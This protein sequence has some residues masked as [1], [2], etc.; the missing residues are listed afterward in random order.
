[1]VRHKLEGRHSRRQ[2]HLWTGSTA[3]WLMIARV[4][5]WFRACHSRRVWWGREAGLHPFIRMVSSF[6]MQNSACSLALPDFVHANS[7]WQK[8]WNNWVSAVVWRSIFY[9]CNKKEMKDIECNSM[10]S[11]GNGAKRNISKPS[12][13]L[14]ARDC[15]FVVLCKNKALQMLF[16]LVDIAVIQTVAKNMSAHVFDMSGSHLILLLLVSQLTLQG[17]WKCNHRCFH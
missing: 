1:M 7:K 3:L 10:H 14:M 2:C 5:V 9:L 6:D 13:W 4:F 15:S 8:K 11:L 17:P 12:S 16:C